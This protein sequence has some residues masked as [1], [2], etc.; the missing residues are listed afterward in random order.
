MAEDKAGS[1]ST[2]PEE[3]S[4]CIGSVQNGQ[5]VCTFVVTHFSIFAVGD[6]EV[7]GRAI[8]ITPPASA[9]DE[10]ITIAAIIGGVVGAIAVIGVIANV[11]IKVV[12]AKTNNTESNS[13]K[14]PFESQT[15]L[16]QYDGT[17]ERPH[18][19]SQEGLQLKIQRLASLQE[20]LGQIQ[21]QNQQRQLL[22]Q[23]QQ[24]RLEQHNGPYIRQMQQ[25][26]QQLEQYQS[27]YIRQQQLERNQNPNAL[28]Y[29]HGQSSAVTVSIAVNTQQV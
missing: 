27:P 2:S 22:Q 7:L 6:P 17:R 26:Q 1:P 5:C 23:L 11:I 3:M 21:E 24:Q 16:N 19:I 18:S 20:Q 4:K 15:E 12:N 13:N 25:P 29:E 10:W 28:Q 14:P 8:Q 9:P